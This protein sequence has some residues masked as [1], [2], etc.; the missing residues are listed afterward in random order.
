LLLNYRSIGLFSLSVAIVGSAVGGAAR[1]TS[2]A[3]TTAQTY[4][5]AEGA[6]AANNTSTSGGAFE[7]TV[8]SSGNTSIAIPFGVLG[9]YAASNTTFGMGVAGISTSGYA[10]GAE[11]LGTSPA[12]F[13]ESTGTG[14][15][16][17]L[18]TTSSTPTALT[19]SS[20]NSTGLA[21]TTENGGYGLEATADNGI[22]LQATGNTAGAFSSV[23]GSGGF[24]YLGEQSGIGVAAYGNDASSAKLPALLSQSEASP[25]DILDGY[26]STGMAVF[27]IDSGTGGESSIAPS[28]GSDVHLEGDLYVTGGIYECLQKDGGCSALGAKA[29]KVPDTETR[30]G[31]Y[32]RTFASQSRESTIEDFGLGH[33]VY[34]SAYVRLDP[35]IASAL[36]GRA[37]YVVFITPGGESH[38]LYFSNRSAQGFEVHETGSGRSTLDFSYRIVATRPSTPVPSVSHV[39]MKAPRNEQMHGFGHT[40]LPQLHTSSRPVPAPNAAFVALLHPDTVRAINVHRDTTTSSTAQ[41]VPGSE[42]AVA[43][44]NTATAGAALEGTVASAGNTSEAIPFGFLGEYTAS[45]STFGV[46]VIGI[47]TSGYGV[48]AEAFGSSVAILG[49]NAASTN[50]PGMQLVT[51]SVGQGMQV[52]SAG[53]GLSSTA[54]GAGY[55]IQV[56]S[57]GGQYAVYAT[58][59]N[60][61]AASF[62]SNFVKT[63]GQGSGGQALLGEQQGAGI[64]AL[65]YDNS[66]VHYPA[67][68]AESMQGGDIFDGYNDNGSGAVFQINGKT[69]ND[70][71][72]APSNGTDVTAYGNFYVNGGIFQCTTNDACTAVT[73]SSSDAEERQSEP[74]VEDLGEAT[75]QGGRG[76]VRLDPKFVDTTDPSSRYLVFLTPNG[77]GAT[78]YYTNLTPA[79]FEVRESEHGR[80]NLSFSYRIVAKPTGIAQPRFPPVRTVKGPSRKGPIAGLHAQHQSAQRL[81]IHPHHLTSLAAVRA[82]LGGR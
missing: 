33:V 13:S 45:N 54:G 11:V 41:L 40:R 63:G 38:G 71:G 37:S 2:E 6:F 61:S 75:L 35:A 81:N 1:S 46:G 18:A 82:A 30:E 42:G 19:I 60:S 65:G 52:Q 76:Y 66:S 21:I 43:Y 27:E 69:L 51:T 14:P 77:D 28:D 80:S 4:S 70:S 59:T 23:G 72:L 5:G 67:L 16:L 29:P 74:T 68:L 55:G 78:L 48:A 31:R 64:E 3:A 36:A 20:K 39:E 57:Q 50:G 25:S 7:G 24:A 62:T 34:G 26:N 8:S 79:G 9:D 10:I 53:A 47:S 15:A 44:N 49:L 32:V 73:Q 17:Q 12:L 56:T 22:A 58:S